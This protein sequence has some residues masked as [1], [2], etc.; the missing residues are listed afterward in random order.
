[1]KNLFTIAVL[2]FSFTSLFANNPE[3]KLWNNK[4]ITQT[5]KK[6]DTVLIKAGSD[7][8]KY[9]TSGKVEFICNGEYIKVNGY[10]IKISDIDVITKYYHIK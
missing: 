8:A 9:V 10:F 3:P 1:M 5:F 2:L 6:G 4:G 7:S